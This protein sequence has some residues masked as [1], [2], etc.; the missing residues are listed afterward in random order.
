MLDSQQQ[1]ELKNPKDTDVESLE[2]EIDS[3]T[4]EMSAPRQQH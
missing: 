4:R 3:H 1:S 2:V